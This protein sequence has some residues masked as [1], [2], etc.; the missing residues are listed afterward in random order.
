MPQF[1]AHMSIAGGHANAVEA[2]VKVGFDTVQIFTKN[3]KQWSAPRITDDDAA[4]FRNALKNAGMPPAVGHASYLINLASP[5]DVTRAKSVAAMIDEVVRADQL[6][7]TDLVMHPGAHMKAGV[8]AGIGRIAKSLDEIHVAT[9]GAG[10]RI[11]LETTAGQGTSVGH[12][13]E[14]LAGILAGVAAP[15]RL[16]VCVDTCHIFAA[17]YSLD[18]TDKYDV[19]IELLERTVGI[20]RVRV[21][22]IN[23]SVKGLGSRVDRHAAIGRGLIPQASFE[24]VLKDPRF[25]GCPMILETPKGEEQGRDLDAVN[26]EVLR[27]LSR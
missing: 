16:S 6:G 18:P 17:G 15:E 13:L 5:D 10:V 4:R 22:H 26:L 12:E 25:A 7:L 3:N 1:G 23:D 20:E 11:A 8:E 9:A 21:W 2:S 14:H 19:W 27:R 24:R